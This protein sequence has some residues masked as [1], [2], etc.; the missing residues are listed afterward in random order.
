LTTTTFPFQLGDP[1][2]HRGI[3]IAPLFPLRD[4]RARYIALDAALAR[5]LTITETSEAGDVPELTVANPLAE[6]VLLYD[7]AELVGAKQNRI[8]NV[9]VLVAAGST[10]RIP[11]SCTEQG[12]WRSVS[13]SFS[14]APHIVNAELRRR[15]AAALSAEP[16]ARGVAQ[17]EVWKTVRGHAERLGSVSP[18]AAHRDLFRSRERELDALAPEFRA[19]PG[20]C[21]AVLGLGEMLCLDAVSRPDVF[22]DIWPKLRRGYLLDALEQLDQ[23]A[24]PPKRLLGFVDEVVDAPPTRGPAAGLGADVRLKGPGVLGSGLELHGETIQLSVYSTAEPAD[25][26][27]GGRSSVS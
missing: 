21:G 26:V 18:T 12:R 6:D 23:P 7:G 17:Q 15:K 1:V 25:P 24:T 14:P 16:L 10:L 9:S 20:Q 11:V 5:G 13:K 3:V 4:P 22:A 27:G 2:E 8:L 19:E